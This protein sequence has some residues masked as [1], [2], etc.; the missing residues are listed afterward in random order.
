MRPSL[1]KRNEEST[2]C[3]SGVANQHYLF[4]ESRSQ[5]YQPSIWQKRR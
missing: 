5:K 1:E 2:V 4:R 3:S